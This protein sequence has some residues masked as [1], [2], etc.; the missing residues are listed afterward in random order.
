MKAIPALLTQ[1]RCSRKGDTVGTVLR[2][3][4]T[5]CKAE[6]RWPDGTVTTEPFE[7]VEYVGKKSYGK[8]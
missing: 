4:V 8:K 6:I 3:R 7:D 1:V 5:A 2:V